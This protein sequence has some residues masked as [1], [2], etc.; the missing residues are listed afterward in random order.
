MMAYILQY[1]ITFLLCAVL[2]SDKDELE[3]TKSKTSS[4]MR[5][6]KPFLKR[7]LEYI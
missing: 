1:E 2:E 7:T 6:Q 4:R 3:S 5:T